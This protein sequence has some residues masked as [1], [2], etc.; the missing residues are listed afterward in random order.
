MSLR[1]AFGPAL[2]ILLLA[3]GCRDDSARPGITGNIDPE[4]TPTMMTRDVETLISDSGITRYRITAPLW[5]IFDEASEPRW[6]FPKTLHLEKYDDFLH[7]IA[8]VDCDSATYW[9]NRQ[10]WQLDGNVRIENAAKEKFL[11]TQ[12]F[13]DQRNHTVYS[14]SF[15]HIEKPD[16]T[17]EGYGFTANERMTSYSVRRVSGIFPADM[18]SMHPA[19]PASPSASSN[20]P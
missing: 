9:K 12:L 18:G 10:L 5:L 14:D 17:L 4:V 11:T 20:N 2:M 13:W 16:R 3:Q 15:I 8:T 19:A 1:H 6:R 7:K